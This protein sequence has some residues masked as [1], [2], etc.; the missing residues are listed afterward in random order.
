MNK[1]TSRTRRNFA[2]ALLNSFATIFLLLSLSANGRAQSGNTATD[3]FTPEGLKTGAPAGSFQLSDFDNINYF[4][5]L[6]TTV[7]TPAQAQSREAMSPRRPAIPTPP[8]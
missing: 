4:N 6:N 5:E 7:T 8:N 3:G 2:F 1:L